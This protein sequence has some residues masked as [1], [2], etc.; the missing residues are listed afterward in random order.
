MTRG[1]KI[2]FWTTV[3]VAATAI[4]A[5]L[6]MGAL[7][8]RSDRLRNRVE[9]AL[10]ESLNLDVTIEALSMGLLPRPRVTGSHVVMRLRD[11]P[12]MPPLITIEHFWCDA[13]YLAIRRRHVGTIHVDG[14]EIVVPPGRGK[15]SFSPA[16]NAAKIA[17]DHLEAHDA[18]L[19]VLRSKPGDEPFVY[20]LHELRIDDIGAGRQSPFYVRMT[21][22][23]PKGHI[24]SDG[25]MGPW[26]RDDPTA[27]PLE[28]GEFKFTDA[29]LSTID[30]IG[31]TLTSNGTYT[32]ADFRISPSSAPR[33]SRT[34]IS[35]WAASPCR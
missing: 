12:D 11:R 4:A 27:M 25:R 32:A 21:N 7:Y 22:P 26:Q 18:R 20:E 5:S 29:D 14:L 17:A 9:R 23:I 10:S 2:A 6:I 16:N 8:L 19:T 1:W 31:G 35:T 28:C 13:G 15:E 30:D 34:S 3:A 24:E 33:R